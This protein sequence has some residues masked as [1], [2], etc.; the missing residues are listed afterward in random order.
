[1][2]MKNQT[3]EKKKKK[4]TKKAKKA[5]SV[6]MMLLMCILLLSAATYAWFSLSNTAR[7]NNLTM[8]V[9]EADGLRVA[10][11][12]G[13]EPAESEWSGSISLDEVKGVLVPATTS[14]GKSFSKPEYDDEGKVEKV[15]ALTGTDGELTKANT[16]E[17]KEGY[18]YTFT[19]YMQSLGADADIK[20]VRGTD[21]GNPSRKG[22][23]VVR[24]S[25]KTKDAKTTQDNAAA[26]LRISIQADGSN[27]MGIYEP[28]ADVTFTGTTT[29]A[30]TSYTKVGN[31]QTQ[32]QGVNGGFGASY[33]S[34]NSDM[35]FHLTKD[36]KTKITL[37]IWVEGEDD[38]CVNQIELDNL[39]MQLQF[40]KDKKTN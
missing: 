3:D 10:L 21:L 7:V 32:K 16:D 31:Y 36:K 37:H 34:D 8:T 28:C 39:L 17:K 25:D 5:R 30:E 38:Q 2:I 14:D 12:K 22:T 35:I 40:M 4:V 33:S 9:S 15:T 23:Y 11:D 20:L 26:A 29:A 19:F 24:N 27:T 6:V 13:S 18:Y 1:M